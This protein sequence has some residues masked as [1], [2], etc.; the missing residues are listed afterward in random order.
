MPVGDLNEIFAKWQAV[1]EGDNSTH[2]TRP[3]WDDM[4][5]GVSSETARRVRD[6]ERR[7]YEASCCDLPDTQRRNVA[8]YVV[9]LKLLGDITYNRPEWIQQAA[10]QGLNGIICG[11][12]Q[13]TAVYRGAAASF[14]Q[15]PVPD[16]ARPP[17]N[18]LVRALR[19][20]AAIDRRA[21]AELR[22]YKNLDRYSSGEK[23]TKTFSL[24]INRA[25]A[26]IFSATQKLFGR[27]VLLQLLSET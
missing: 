19:D 2:D 26:D 20:H 3:S 4:L 14:E 18:R 17:H 27:A 6:F 12:N 10:A 22:E 11:L 16:G 24:A 13:R 23:E 5:A 1:A 8:R 15:L 21:A 7:V 9:M 25:A